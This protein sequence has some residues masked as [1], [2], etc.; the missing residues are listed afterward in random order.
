MLDLGVWM[1]IQCAGTQV[2]QMGHCP[3][4]ALAKSVFDAWDNRLSSKA[5]LSIHERL[6]IVF[7]C[8]YD[9]K[10]GN[11]LVEMNWG[12]LFQK[13]T[14]DALQLEQNFPDYT[15]EPEDLEFE[16]VWVSFIFFYIFHFYFYCFHLINLA[17]F[18]Y[19]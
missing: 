5:F 11:Y 7:S 19:L 14:L 12:K 17:I 13:F 9:D 8:I 10:G 15:S 3:H 16:D 1:S 2:H 18:F 4:N 6:K